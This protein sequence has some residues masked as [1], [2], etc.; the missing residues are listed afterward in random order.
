MELNNFSNDIIH[1][2]TSDYGFLL[3]LV[4]LN[5][6]VNFQ[7]YLYRVRIAKKGDLIN[8]PQNLSYPKNNIKIGRCN[9]DNQAVFYCCDSSTTAFAETLKYSK[10]LNF[11]DYYIYLSVWK[12][13]PL[14]EITIFPLLN[15]AFFFLLVKN[16]NI[17]NF[18]N[19]AINNSVKNQLIEIEKYFYDID[20]NKSASI[21][22]FLFNRDYNPCDAIF[23]PSKIKKESGVNIAFRTEFVDENLEFQRGYKFEIVKESDT[24]KLDFLKFTLSKSNFIWETPNW[25]HFLIKKF[26]EIDLKIMINTKNLSLN[27]K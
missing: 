20:Y 1:Q 23:Y 11:T 26:T 7:N 6:T 27:I 5:N 8:E 13:K 9:F 25:E 12:L 3:N 18:K 24:Y 16:S 22:N 19:Y 17:I 10:D 14:N 2:L 4:N 15:K 21:S